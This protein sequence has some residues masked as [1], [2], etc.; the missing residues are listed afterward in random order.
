[1]QNLYVY[2]ITLYIY[3]YIEILYLYST[4]K[5]YDKNKKTKQRRDANK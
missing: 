2:M 4:L 5:K 1:M 3:I